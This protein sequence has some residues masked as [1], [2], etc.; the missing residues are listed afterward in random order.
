[1][2]GHKAKPDFVVWTSLS[3]EL[4]WLSWAWRLEYIVYDCMFLVGW[5]T[6]R[7]IN[8]RRS[9]EGAFASRIGF[10]YE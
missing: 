8:R 4:L 2:V 3:V 5:F 1:V 6:G 9:G 7:H 10:I